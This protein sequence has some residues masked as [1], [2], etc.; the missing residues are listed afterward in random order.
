LAEHW[1][2]HTW[3]TA[4]VPLPTG[5]MGAAFDGVDEVG[6]TNVWAVGEYTDGQQFNAM[7]FV[8]WNCTAW[9]FVKEPAALHNSALRR[10][11]SAASPPSPSAA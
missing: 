9:S 4:T 11:R 5:A 2:G 7:L 10:R 3:S 8:H 6:S 1:D